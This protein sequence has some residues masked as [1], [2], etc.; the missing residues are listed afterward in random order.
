LQTPEPAK[1]AIIPVAQQRKLWVQVQAKPQARV[2]GGIE[3]FPSL[4]M[5]HE[6]LIL[7]ISLACLKKSVCPGIK[8]AKPLPDFCKSCISNS[9][10]IKDALFLHFCAT[11][12]PTLGE[13]GARRRLGE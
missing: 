5:T 1:L 12:R 6:P 11:I 2:A 8:P 9:W 3:C 13:D 7:K 10:I 4:G